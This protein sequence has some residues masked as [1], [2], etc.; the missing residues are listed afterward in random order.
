M[1]HQTDATIEAEIDGLAEG[2]RSGGLP[3]LSQ[4]I[5]ERVSRKPA[6]MGV[7]LLTDQ[8]LKPLAGNLDGW[9][10]VP[11]SPD[12]WLNFSLEN[13]SMDKPHKARGRS[14]LL[15][16]GFYLLVGRD[17]Y[18]LDKTR[19]LI[20]HTLSWGLLVTVGLALL[21]GVMMSKT[22]LKRIDVINQTSREIISGD[23]SR[24]IPSIG[25]GDEIDDLVENLNQM[26]NQI[27]VLMDDVK[28]VSDNIA[29]DLRTPLA[30]LRNRLETLA[31]KAE[32][33]SV[34]HENARL[35][36]EE[37]DSLLVT[38]NAL[39]RIARIE[40]A[41][42]SEYFEV[43]D[44]K[45]LV[46]DVAELYEPL[47]EE[48]G[49]RLE[50][51]LSD[52]PTVHGDRNL[53][54]QAIANFL[55]NACKYTPREGLI[56]I[57]LEARNA[58]EKIIIADSGPGIPESEREKVFRRFYRMETSRSTQGN[59]L[60]L[61]LAMAIVKQHRGSVELQDNNPGLRV[62]LSFKTPPAH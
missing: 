41:K 28:R 53:L 22:M 45:T 48:R 9:P 40:S 34:E 13:G 54:F 60:G 15:R 35:A 37:A 52:S 44:L 19:Q 62:V 50:L 51:K 21:G 39:L 17:T 32:V 7:Y 11:L 12:G 55:D 2:Y 27:E 61:S 16:G 58:S 56:T 33:N 38:F 47:I 18:E 49:Q 42:Q 25:S 23:L 31:N 59:G 29:H 43:I 8:Q 26:L 4:L 6:G 30:R 57:L 14:Y 5:L 36:L 1:V 24:R 46:L 3:R 10:R 20:D